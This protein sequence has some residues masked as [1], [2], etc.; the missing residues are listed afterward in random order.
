MQDATVMGKVVVVSFGVYWL[1]VRLIFHAE[2][3]HDECL[4]VGILL[5][6]LGAM[7]GGP[8]AHGVLLGLDAALMLPVR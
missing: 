4:N 7:G 3:V 6:D 5:D 8:L 1:V 2:V